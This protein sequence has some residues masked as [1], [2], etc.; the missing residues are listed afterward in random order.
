MAWIDLHLT[1]P[2]RN[3]FRRYRV[4]EDRTLFA[5][6]CLI[7]EW[8]RIGTRLRRREEVFASEAAL[9]RRLAELLARR[10]YHGY[11]PVP[12]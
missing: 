9:A 10:R 8:G 1:D 5:E 2:A 12:A 3:R 11:V 7:I 6:P 4:H